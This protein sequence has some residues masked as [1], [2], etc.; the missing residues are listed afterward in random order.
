L[1]TLAQARLAAI[2]VTIT[3]ALQADCFEVLGGVPNVVIADRL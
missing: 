1:L 2:C 3:L